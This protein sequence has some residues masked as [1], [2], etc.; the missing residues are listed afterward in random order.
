MR[1]EGELATLKPFGRRDMNGPGE[2]T[3]A[4]HWPRP[5]LWL[6]VT[7]ALLLMVATALV[8]IVGPVAVENWTVERLRRMPG[9]VFHSATADVQW[10]TNLIDEIR[11]PKRHDIALGL[12]SPRESLPLLTRLR[13][14]NS[15]TL[16][17]RHIR[18]DDLAILRRLPRLKGLTISTPALGADWHKHLDGLPLKGVSL[19][20]LTVPAGAFEVISRSPRWTDL[21]LKNADFL[22]DDFA[23]LRNHP[24]IEWMLLKDVP[25]SG[26]DLETIG[27]LSA[28]DSLLLIDTDVSAAEL[29]R[30]PPLPKLKYLK[31][32]G[33]EITDECLAGL[34]VD[35]QVLGV[36]N[37][38]VAFGAST[39]TW[40]KSCKCC[41][42]I[43]VTG[44][45]IS[46]ARI[47]YLNTLGPAQLYEVDQSPGGGLPSP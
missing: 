16:E 4:R 24:G 3:P 25:L 31:L 37:T 27:S 30:L 26:D 28:L 42:K 7:L 23:K 21:Y 2:D 46:P 44:L 34:R 14:V 35:P 41:R 45:G 1:V 40:L 9:V 20:N 6:V 13:D 36:C 5:P 39:E 22:S 17:S 32:E 33:K 47:Q 29:R 12:D 18:D 19:N 11:S 43:N 15:L 8:S 10:D 38:S